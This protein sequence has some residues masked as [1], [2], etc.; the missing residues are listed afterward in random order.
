MFLYAKE[1]VAATKQAA[2]QLSLEAEEK[3]LNER[4]AFY[5]TVIVLPV[6]LMCCIPSKICAAILISFQ[7]KNPSQYNGYSFVCFYFITSSEFVV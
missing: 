4:K 2:N 6:T 3:L 7:E 1:S 5:T